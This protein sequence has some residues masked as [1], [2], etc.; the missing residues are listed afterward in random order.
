MYLPEEILNAKV[1]IS[2]KTYPIPSKK[3]EELVCNAGFLENGKWIRIYPIPF[4]SLPYEE[5]YRKYTWIELDLVR[6]HRDFRPESYRPKRGFEEPIKHISKVDTKDNWRE[7]KK[8]ALKEVYHSM[9][10]L[11]SHAKEK[12]RW[13]S[14]ATLKP[15]EIVDFVIE[16]DDRE[17]S[18][19]KQQELKQMS[20]FSMHK[21]KSSEFNIVRKIP[22]KF[23]YRFITEGDKKPR[24][25]MIED[26][27]IGALYWNCL[28][29]A[30]GDEEIAKQQ[31]RKK[32][33]QEFLSGNK[34]IHLFLG[35]TQAHHHRSKNPF[36]IIGV[37]YPPITR[38][39]SL[40]DF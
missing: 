26:W 40:F 34:D 14:L 22:Y 17:W 31:V 20:L 8:Y 4:R 3:Y 5:Q 21:N 7:R 30:N 1:L 29:R 39:R 32:Y 2:V 25:L 33:E 11:I 6:N 16:D 10:E 19:Q 18:S 9:N 15:K 35:T 38:Q 27:E 12:N 24:K 13:K 36:V 28:R 37:F 23:Y